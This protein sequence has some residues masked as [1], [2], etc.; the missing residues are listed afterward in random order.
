VLAHEL[1]NTLIKLGFISSAINTEFGYLREQWEEQLEKAFPNTETRKALLDR[2]SRLAESRLPSLNGTQELVCLSRAIIREQMELAHLAPMPAVGLAWLE[3]K[4]RPKWMRLLS[5]TDAWE[6]DR[7]EILDILERLRQGGLGGNGR[8]P[9]RKIGHLPEEIR[10]DWPRLAY[11]DFSVDKL[12]TLDE[13]IRFLDHP[14]LAIPHKHQTRKILAYLGAIVEIMPEMEERANRII[15]SLKT[16]TLR[17][18]RLTTL[19]QY[20]TIQ[21]PFLEVEGMGFTRKGYRSDPSNARERKP[22]R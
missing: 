17:N 10:R 5:E 6:T 2:L 12:G 22:V 11:V 13:T 21:H 1:R 15:S 4:I 3:H 19:V 7:D 8:Y 18:R 20:S 14:E 16:E 9:R